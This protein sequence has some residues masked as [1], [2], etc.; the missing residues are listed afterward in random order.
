MLSP[1]LLSCGQVPVL[2]CWSQVTTESGHRTCQ[3]GERVAYTLF[4]PQ[5]L[6][7]FES[8]P[9]PCVVLMHGFARSQ[10]NHHATA[11][12]LAEQGMMVMTPDQVSLLGGQSAQLRNIEILVDH[13]KWLRARAAAP[14]DALE[15]LIDPQRIGLV[16]HSAGGAICFEA[17]LELQDS[18]TPVQAL[19]L[20]DGVPWERTIARAPLLN[21]MAFLSLRSAPSPCNDNA[22]VL[23]L[24]EGLP[25]QVEDVKVEGATHCDAENPSDFLCRV[26]CG[27]STPEA[28]ATY[29]E[30]LSGFLIESLRAAP[31]STAP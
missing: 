24:L 16:G 17:T 19:C 13:V 15:G 2:D 26:L 8:P 23:Q 11:R 3:T 30:L 28:R 29:Q 6:P 14:G 25:F 4:V 1:A 10:R 27:G 18:G 22:R 5:V 12:A 21:E 31:P 9:W 20:L 7:E